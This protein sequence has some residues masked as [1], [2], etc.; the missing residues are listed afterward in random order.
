MRLATAVYLQSKRVLRTRFEM[1]QQQGVVTTLTH[2]I[3]HLMISIHRQ[4]WRTWSKLSQHQGVPTS[5]GYLQ[6]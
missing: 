5:G 2:L 1:S 3:L 6:R 4:V